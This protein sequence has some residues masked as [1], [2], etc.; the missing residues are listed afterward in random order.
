[1]KRIAVIAH[2]LSGG[3]AERVAALVANYFAQNNYDV[4]FVA[5]YNNKRE[6]VLDERIKYVFLK[7]KS[8][9]GTLCM[10]ERSFLLKKQVKKFKADAAFSFI[11]NELIPLVLSR[12]PVIPSL[13]MD[14]KY[15]EKYYL[16]KKIRL[17]VYHHAKNIIFQTE[18]ARDYFDSSIRKK[19]VVIG[20]PIKDN[21]PYWKEEGHRKVFVTACRISKQKNIPMLI[22]S[23]SEFHKT[24]S[25]YKLEIYGDGEPESYKQE[26]EDY[27]KKIKADSFIH[28]MG[29]TS[30]IHSIMSGCEAFFLT[31]DCEGLSNSMLE[32]LAI[33]IPSVCTDCPPGG[34]KIYMKDGAGI[35][36]D[37]G[38]EKA[39]T[40]AMCSI[41]ESEQLRKELSEKEKYVRQVLQKDAVCRKW[42]E[43]IRE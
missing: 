15:I 12:I 31:S 9:N 36:I 38:D 43:L 32:A 2:G 35:L 19:G 13:R 18:D 27:C 20:N 23:F 21:L 29:H 26:M 6:Y 22:N 24:H 37:V 41:A 5:C 1:M 3:G 11:T 17:F 25:D 39:L 40:K 28:F 30:E 14:P 33:G 10:I 16:R 8:E 4:L 42:E 34:A 7:T